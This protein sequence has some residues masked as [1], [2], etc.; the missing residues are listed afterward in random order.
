MHNKCIQ[1]YKSACCTNKTIILNISF[2]IIIHYNFFFL[3]C[4][5]S[6]AVNCQYTW[7]YKILQLI[8]RD[9]SSVKATW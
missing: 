3:S 2:P 5:E 8:D 4:L 7:R 6:S 1:K 9:L